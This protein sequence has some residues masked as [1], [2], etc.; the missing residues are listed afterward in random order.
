[1]WKEDEEKL[2]KNKERNKPKN[3][4]IIVRRKKKNRR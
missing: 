2:N 1:M 4:D 3:I